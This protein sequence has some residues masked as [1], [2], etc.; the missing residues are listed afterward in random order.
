[1]DNTTLKDV[2]D[3]CEEHRVSDLKAMRRGGIWIV[4]VAH[5]I[6]GTGYLVPT[7]GH[8]PGLEAAWKDATGKVGPK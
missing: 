6:D 1:M 7:T 4:S 2:Q 3:W 8:G 5:R